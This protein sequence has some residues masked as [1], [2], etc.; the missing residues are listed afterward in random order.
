MRRS[1]LAPVLLTAA[2]SGC[3]GDRR[4]GPVPVYVS[5]DRLMP[6]HPAVGLTLMRTRSLDP[7][8]GVVPT[9]RTTD[10]TTSQR[11][12]APLIPYILPTM[13]ARPV[14]QHDS[15]QASDRF[16]DIERQTARFAEQAVRRE[17]R[18]DQAAVEAERVEILRKADEQIVARQRTIDS[19]YR[20]RLRDVELRLIALGTQIGSPVA[21]P[22]E[23][24][25]T[26]LDEARAEKRR[27]E[28]ERDQAIA[29]IRI[30]EIQ[31][32]REAIETIEATRTRRREIR[33]AERAA[34]IARTIALYRERIHGATQELPPMDPISEARPVFDHPPAGQSPNTADPRS[35]IS[36]P[37]DALASLSDVMLRAIR[38]E[39][40][41]SVTDIG[42]ELGWEIHY[43]RRPGLADHTADVARRLV[44]RYGSTAFDPPARPPDGR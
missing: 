36:L 30:E 21:G 17:Q 7:S 42:S 11:G 20:T 4:T 38:N 27:L 34:E 18:Q 37:A 22:P 6:L 43:M 8:S 2:L 25:K 32:A 5:L 40:K 35:M 16:L 23:A 10:H 15:E 24:V 13:A 1:L 14:A 9:R 19:S 26:A 12:M 44:A 39:V 3:A 31:A 41:A 28:R 33:V 29:A